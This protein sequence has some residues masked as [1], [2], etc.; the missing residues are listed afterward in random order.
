MAKKDYVREHI[1]SPFMHNKSIYNNDIMELIYRRTISSM[2]MARFKWEGLPDS[3]DERYLELTL[4]QQGLCVFYFDEEYDRFLA[5]KASASGMINMYDNPTSFTVIGNSMVNKTIAG[6]DCVPIWA[7]IYRYPEWDLIIK[8]AER[9]SNVESTIDQ[10]IRAMRTPFIISANANDKLTVQNAYKQIV[11]GQPVIIATDSFGPEDVMNKI[12]LFTTSLP[13][14][15]LS[16]VHSARS[17][18]MNECLTMLGIMNTNTEKKE[19]MIVEEATGSSGNVLAMRAIYMRQREI[20]CEQIN[21]M[22]GLNVSCKWVLDD[23]ASSNFLSG[24]I[25][26]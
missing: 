25:G 9:L 8:Y 16:E 23:G 21:K 24:L 12:Q 4:L 14:G 6:N 26:E 19:R 2:C 18:I 11:E 10:N 1:Y 22:Y 7:N 13:H 3:I 5:L 15:V 20:A 17:R